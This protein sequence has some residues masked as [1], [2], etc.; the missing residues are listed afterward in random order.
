MIIATVI[1]SS[2]RSLV[3]ISEMISINQIIRI[4]T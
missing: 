4:F 3:I 2:S 1:A